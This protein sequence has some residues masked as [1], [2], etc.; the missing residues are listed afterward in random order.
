[1]S[2]AQSVPADL[3][4]DL[5]SASTHPTHPMGTERITIPFVGQLFRNGDDD[6]KVELVPF[7][8]PTII[9]EADTED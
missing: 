9:E 3:A 4:I 6:F 1:M 7:I 5:S 2:W 8:S